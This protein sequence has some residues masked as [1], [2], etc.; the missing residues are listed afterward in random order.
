[1]LLPLLLLLWLVLHV[2][3]M[4]CTLLISVTHASVGPADCW[5]YCCLV[6]GKGSGDVGL[7]HTLRGRTKQIRQNLHS[8]HALTHDGRSSMK[9]MTSGSLIP[10]SPFT[11]GI[12]SCLK[13]PPQGLRALATHHQ[14]EAGPVRHAGFRCTRQVPERPGGLC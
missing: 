5:V 8:T 13:V 6:M 9:G 4:C 12:C 1:V 3:T 7:Q 10:L 2:Q 11:T 14:H